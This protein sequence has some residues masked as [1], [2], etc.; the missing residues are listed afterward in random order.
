VAASSLPTKSLAP[1]ATFAY[2]WV[3]GDIRGLAAFAGT[4]YG[5]VPEI[6]N[7]ITALDRK[8]SQIVGDAGWQGAAASAFTSNW[9]QIS[10]ETSAV[11]LVIVQTGS[12]VDQLAVNLSRV[13]NALEQAADKTEAHGVQVGADGQPPQASYA[14]QTQED[15]RV[16]YASFYQQCKAAAE[17]ARV[18]AAGALHDVYGAMTS[19]K[20]GKHGKS[21]GKSGKSD[22]AEDL[23]TKIGE[24]GTLAGLL[25][26]LLATKTAYSHEVAATVAEL[27]TKAGDA[28]DVWK[29]AQAA[30]RRADGRFG[31][32]PADVKAELRDVKAELAAEETVLGKAEAG[33]NAFS[34]IFGTRL[35]DVPGVKGS[36]AIDALRDGSLLDRAFDIPV[37][38]VVAGGIATVVS[39]Q[40]DE[41]AGIPGYVAYPWE[42]GGTVTSIVVGT[43]AAT[44]V[45]GA[46][47]GLAIAGAPELGVAAGIVTCAVVTYGVGDYLHNLILDYGDQNAAEASTVADTKQ[48]ADD[49]GHLTAHAASSVWHKLTSS[50]F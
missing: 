43:M 48:L 8:V 7:V 46:V 2:D 41:K 14:S 12:I 5:Y 30:A 26:D 45:G 3:G 22:P 15:W 19:G 44:V 17:D 34:K 35:R 25:F 9:E 23:G 31:P 6:E 47:A 49:V 4:L 40:E 32:M 16:G 1:L 50:F 11:G 20:P 24:G 39:A 13:E 29:A 36:A 28:F 21:G 10:A 18:Q 38:D 37:V 27:K 33:E 42:A